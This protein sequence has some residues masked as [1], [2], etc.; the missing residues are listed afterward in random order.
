MHFCL[1]LEPKD[2]FS[3]LDRGRGTQTAWR[4]SNLCKTEETQTLPL[5]IPT[6]RKIE[7]ECKNTAKRVSLSINQR[8]CQ[9]SNKVGLNCK[10]LPSIFLTLKRQISLYSPC[11][12]VGVTINFP[13]PNCVTQPHTDQVP[14]STT[15]YPTGRQ[16]FAQ[17]R[18]AFAKKFG[19]GRKIQA[20][21][22]A[23]SSRY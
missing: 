12:L 5:S 7:M 11:R 14:P 4:A 16:K 2:S 17:A 9:F 21:T 15:M 19:V 10:S 8:C 20:L 23:I 22:F 13:P 1:L 3:H 18:R 6:Y